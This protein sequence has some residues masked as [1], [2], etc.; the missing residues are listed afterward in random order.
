MNDLERRLRAALDARAQTIEA[1]PHAWQRLQRRTRR[2]QPARWLL[3]AL[4][5]AMV[6]VFVPI[7]LSGGLG[8]NTAADPDELYRRL[9]RDRTPAGETVTLDGPSDGGAVR[10]WFARGDQGQ[11]EF[12]RLVER[13]RQE[14]YGYCHTLQFTGYSGALGWYEGTTGADAAAA[15]A[16]YGLATANVVQA[17]AELEGGRTVPARLHRPEGLDVVLWTVELAAGERVSR[18]VVADAGGR[19]STVLP[20]GAPR[21]KNRGTPTGAAHGLTDGIT[22]RLYGRDEIAWFRDGVEAGAVPLAANRLPKA[23]GADPVEV[24]ASPEEALLYGVTREDVARFELTVAG[25]PIVVRPIA[26]PWGL[27]LAVYAATLP[28]ASFFREGGQVVAYDAAG[29]EIWRERIPASR[30]ERAAPGR[31]LGE[32]FAVPGTE[33]FMGGPVRL[34]FEEGRGRGRKLCHSGGATHEGDLDRGCGEAELGPDSF[35]YDVLVRHLPLPGSTVAF[36]PARAD[37]LSVDAVTADGRRIPGTVVRP[38]GTPNAAWLVRH[39]SSERVAAYAFTVRGSRREEVHPTDPGACWEASRSEAADHPLPGGLTARLHPGSCL[40]WW[41]DGKDRYGSSQPLPGATLSSMLTA[42]RPVEV[43]LDGRAF[44]GFALRGTARVGVTL[45]D[46]GRA[47]AD[48]APDPWG[49]GVALF[50][51]QGARPVQRSEEI[52][53]YAADGDVLW[54]YRLPD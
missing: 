1:S 43:F 34:W 14:P 2:R 37:W 6:A 35:T 48:A 53:G 31:R 24:R 7:L 26:R 15:H 39:P 19:R 25:A 22:V 44:H 27:R 18:V 46:G 45:E 16:D 20:G 17:T 40:K 30:Q 11:P 51:G 41:K 28:D 5:A 4:P 13:G 52:T 9:M 49:Q 21:S 33:D 54:T 29:E 47:F 36:G 8:R 12:C 50:G 42:E 10:L 3:L 38:K 23:L 32:V